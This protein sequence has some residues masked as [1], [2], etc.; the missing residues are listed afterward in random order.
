MLT[1]P[2][3]H[4]LCAN[5]STQLC[6]VWK[7]NGTA[8]KRCPI[9]RTVLLSHL[10]AKP[11]LFNCSRLNHTSLFIWVPTSVYIRQNYPQNYPQCLNEKNFLKAFYYTFLMNSV[12]SKLEKSLAPGWGEYYETRRNNLACTICGLPTQFEMAFVVRYGN[13]F[14][15]I[16]ASYTV[17]KHRDTPVKCKECLE[18]LED[19]FTEI[20]FLRPSAKAP[21]LENSLEHI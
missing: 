2:C 6:K 17:E 19:D 8:R 16:C 10:F 1:N 15:T 13:F 5:C 14:C 12:P 7:E 4:M 18:D 9:C 3:G 11:A 21:A 20:V